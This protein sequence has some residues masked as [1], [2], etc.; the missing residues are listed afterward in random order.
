MLEQFQTVRTTVALPAA[1]LNRS[2]HFID[3]GSVPSRNALIVAAVEHYLQE[4]ERQEIDR[5]FEAMADDS[6]YLALNEGLA[7]AFADS[8]WEALAEDK[9]G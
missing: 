7:E 8:D 4:L 5:Q 3:A 9:R 2:Q 1:L 6:A